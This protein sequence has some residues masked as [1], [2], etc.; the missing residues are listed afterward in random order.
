MKKSRL[1]LFVSMRPELRSGLRKAGSHV[2]HKCNRQLGPSL[3]ASAV[4]GEVSEG[5]YSP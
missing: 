3:P 5:T 4:E 1:V 2:K